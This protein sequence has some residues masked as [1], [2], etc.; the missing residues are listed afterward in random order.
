MESEEKE[1]QGVEKSFGKGR[2]RKKKKME[3]KKINKT[4]SLSLSPASM[5]L[6]VSTACT[7]RAEGERTPTRS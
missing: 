6:R 3:R 5:A 1:R 7:L 2:K 4:L